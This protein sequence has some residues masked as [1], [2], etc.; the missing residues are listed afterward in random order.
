MLLL[1]S[2]STPYLTGQYYSMQIQAQCNNYTLLDC[3]Q[4]YMCMRL[5]FLISFLVCPSFVY[6]K[7]TNSD[8]CMQDLLP[9]TLLNGFFSSKDFMVDP[10]TSLMYM[11]TS[12]VKRDNMNS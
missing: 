11:T 2:V 5:F 4:W 10:L 12:S 7:A 3:Y 6:I 9:D 1:Q 8:F